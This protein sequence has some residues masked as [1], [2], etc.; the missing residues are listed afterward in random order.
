M[1]IVIQLRALVFY[2]MIFQVKKIDLDIIKILIL[3]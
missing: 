3:R 1:I 2:K